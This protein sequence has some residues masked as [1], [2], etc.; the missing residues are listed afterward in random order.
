MG[1]RGRV[2]RSTLAD[3]NDAHDW[4]IYTDFAQVLIRIAR[5]SEM[6]VAP[7]DSSSVTGTPCETAHLRTPGVR[8]ITIDFL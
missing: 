4:R 3:A 7:S 8:C 6:R 2:A 1:F 5:P